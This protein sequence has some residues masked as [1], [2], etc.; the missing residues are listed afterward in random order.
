MAIMQNSE[1]PFL[2]EYCR[3]GKHYQRPFW[4][5][6]RTLANVSYGAGLSKGF[7]KS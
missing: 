6:F 2:G 3:I 7:I 5:D 4:S 1:S